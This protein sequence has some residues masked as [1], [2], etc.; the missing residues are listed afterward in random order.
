MK[1]FARNVL[2]VAVAALSVTACAN[3]PTA[4]PEA[5]EPPVHAPQGDRLEFARQALI[6]EGMTPS[7]AS[8]IIGACLTDPA[9]LA[10]AFYATQMR[11]TDEQ[12]RQYLS[13]PHPRQEGDICFMLIGQ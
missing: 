3:N 9:R 2:F 5:F 11:M 13:R 8:D 4:K 7:D 1:N 6:D 12:A 10:A